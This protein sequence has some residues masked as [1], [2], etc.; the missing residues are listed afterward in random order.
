[1]LEA[2]AAD[3][4]LL[5]SELRGRGHARAELEKL[6]SRGWLERVE[7]AAAETPSSREATLSSA[8]ELTADQRRAL[9]EIKASGSGFR[10]FLLQGVTGS[11]KTEIYMQL[12]S[13]EIAAGRQSLLLVPEIS[14]TPQLVKRLEQRFGPRL[15]I[16]HSALTDRERLDAW[17]ASRSGRAGLV[18][19][20]RSAVF[21]PLRRPGLVIVDE[22]HDTSFKQAEGFRYSARDLAVYRA[23]QLDLPVVL[24]SATP[25]LESLHNVSQGRYRLLRLPRRIGAAGVPDMRIVDLNQHAS[26]NGLSTPLLAAIEQHLDAGNQIMLFLNRRGFAPALFCAECGVAEECRRCDARMTIHAATGRLRCHHC[27]AERRLAWACPKCGTERVAV[28]AGTQRV[29]EEL[30]ALYPAAR[31][32]R[33]DRDATSR[34]GSLASVLADVEGGKIRILVGTQMLAKGHDFPNVTLVGVLNADQGLFGTDFRS[35]ERLAQTIVQVAGRAGRADQPGE[36]LIQTHFPKHPLFDCLRAQDYSRF[37]ELA[38]AERRSS[39]WPPFSHLVLWRAHASSREIVFDFLARVARV[40][41]AGR[42]GVEVHGPAAAAMERRG[43]RYRAQVLLQCERRTPLHEL[44]SAL[45]AEVRRWPEA[46]KV[47][48]AI[49]VDPAE[50]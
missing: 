5:E 13:A 48:W 15:A 11:G 39:G 16:M 26:R 23:R 30:R 44:V 45:A 27:G 22:E 4:L 50:L 25:S 46:R 41:R 36:V 47:R 24:G 12:I 14:L 28:G 1:V 9:A 33:L 19:G 20:T 42:T 34:R 40:A 49:D 32:G 21:A 38:L 43:D 6:A 3:A 10:A 35:I 18:V 2:L 37:A 17:I 29:T 7:L 8:P 31:I